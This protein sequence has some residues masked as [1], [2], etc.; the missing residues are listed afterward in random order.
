VPS[1]PVT[2]AQTAAAR[3]VSA[4][5]ELDIPGL[6]A[7]SGIAPLVADRTA[8]EVLRRATL[9]LTAARRVGAGT[10]VTYP[11]ARLTIRG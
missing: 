2:G 7:A 8:G 11:R 9:S 4:V 5:A 1:G 10:V 6:S 3:L